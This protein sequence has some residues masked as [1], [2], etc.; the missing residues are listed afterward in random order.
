MKYRSEIDGLRAVAVFPVIL[1]HAGFDLFSGGYVG[2]DIFFV[3]SGFLIT[4]SIMSD[5][6]KGRFSVFGF[7]ERRA[8]RILPALFVVMLA[9]IPF[10]W[11]WMLPDPMENFSQSIVATLLFSN[12]ILLYLTSGYWQQASE[13][14]PLLHTWSLGVEEQYYTIIPVLLMMLVK[15]GGRAVITSI[16]AIAALSF[17]I[18]QY[19]QNAT[20]SAAF[21]LLHTRAWELLVGAVAALETKRFTQW[22]RHD[23]HGY[24]AILG[25]ALTFVP[26]FVFSKQTPTP[27]A[28]M[29]APTLGA[30]LVIL[31]ANPSTWAFRFLSSKLMVGV[32]LTSYSSYL[33][34]QPLFAFA[35]IYA[36][37]EPSAILRLALIPVAF[38]L[39]YYSWRFV[40]TPF[41]N[42]KSMSLKVFSSI[43][44]TVAA[45][46][47]TFGLMGHHYHGFSERIFDTSL[48]NAEM[49]YISYNERNF[50]FKKDAFD[51][52]HKRLLVVGDSFGRDIINIIRETYQEDKLSLVYRDKLTACNIA[53]NAI[54]RSLFDAAHVILFAS[55]YNVDTTCP[56]ELI[57]DARERGKTLFFIGKKHFGH[58]LNWIARIDRDSRSLLSNPHFPKTV[59]E[60]QHTQKRIG[61]DHYISLIAPIST[62]EGI[63]VTDERG[64]LLSADRTHVTQAGAMFLGKRVFLPSTL[65]KY[66]PRK[67]VH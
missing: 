42:R 62:D 15:V 49:M 50:E 22:V 54:G 25:L 11:A 26:I 45:L 36:K 27:G 21:F 20:P 52:P 24:L 67:V 23:Y 35:R 33:W 43:I 10:A 41:R 57:A 31:Y 46:L 39:A 34:H 48:T 58:N 55:N 5:L 63:L 7:Y 32:G 6:D 66:F 13:F 17:L 60:D 61:A 9:C 40:E 12:N 37:D 16:T 56:D 29:L 18:A 2:V 8:R 30:A 59:E 64:R 38:L 19:A 4:K 47:M 65:S 28:Y 3:I 1:F 51:G 44:G 14:K 53:N